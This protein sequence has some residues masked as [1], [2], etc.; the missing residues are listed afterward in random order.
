MAR[1]AFLALSALAWLM[2]AL[3][4][5]EEPEEEA[6]LVSGIEEEAR[7]GDDA[8]R[9]FANVILFVPRHV[10]DFLFWGT[11]VAVAVLENQQ[12]VPRVQG[13]VSTPGGRLAVL[14][15]LFVETGGVFNVGA[16]MIAD[17]GPVATG[18]RLGFGGIHSFE[19][20]PR[21]TF[22]LDVPLSTINVEGLYKQDND[23]EYLG[24][25]QT[26]ERDPRNRFL[27]GQRGEEAEYFEERVRWILGYAVRPAEVVELL[28]SA[29][30]DRRT[31]TDAYDADEDALSKIFQPGSVAGVG[32]DDAHSIVY[33]E[34]AVRVDTRATRGRPS[35]GFL[36]EAYAGGGRAVRGPDV[37][38]LRYGGRLAGFFPIYRTTNILSPRVVLDA[39]APL[40]STELP[41]TELTGQPDF[42]GFD[43]RRDRLSLVGSLDYRWL[44]INSVGFRLFGDAAVVASDYGN[45]DFAA[46]RWALG[47]ALDLHTNSTEV[48]Q[49]GFSAAPDGVRLLLSLGVPKSYGDRQHRD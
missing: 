11:S 3:A 32:E 19:V 36:G 34:S 42:R 28:A 6:A 39:V 9:D 10:A 14:P 44:I 21:M 40:G 29:S 22:R 26:P 20:E 33:A 31:V 45:I 16:R 24:V 12:V 17:L 38:L 47:M 27:P 37:A 43:T 15:T 25:G 2:P 48:G 49:L 46:T 23:L 8:G 35:A 30:L 7:H 1:A 18:L 13:F 5:A 4:Q 41:F